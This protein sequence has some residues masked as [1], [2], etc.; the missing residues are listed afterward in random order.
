MKSLLAGTAALALCACWAASAL[1]DD[2]ARPATD[3]ATEFARAQTLRKA[4]N[5][6]EAASAL[7]QLM[8]V[9]PDDPRV[10]NRD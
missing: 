10:M 9:A 6:P 8:L 2:A 7:A 4:G 5:L 3:V 1:A